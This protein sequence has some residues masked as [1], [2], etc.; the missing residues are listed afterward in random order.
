MLQPCGPTKHGQAIAELAILSS[1]VLII[2]ASI[3]S[4]GQRFDRV[5]EVKMRAFRKA[6]VASYVRNA[7]VNYT[8]KQDFRGMDF[9]NFGKGQPL[10]SMGSSTV[11]WQ[12]GITGTPEEEKD[13]ARG[14]YSFYEVN[15]KLLGTYQGWDAHHYVNDSAGSNAATFPYV[16]PSLLRV[17]RAVYD[18]TQTRQSGSDIYTSAGIYKNVD[19]HISKYAVTSTRDEQGTT[20]T[21]ADNA[22]NDEKGVEDIYWRSDSNAIYYHDPGAP[23]VNQYSTYDAS[24]SG[25]NH[26]E[27]VP[28]FVTSN[29]TRMDGTSANEVRLEACDPTVSD[30]SKPLSANRSWTTAQ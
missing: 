12:K 29:V 4:Y 11:L 13:D 28:T 16:K 21:N 6:L 2:F 20:L 1:L 27:V 14:S 26:I 10:T 18:E 30:C 9:F 17:K 8:L 24:N 22:V 5:G 25:S 7:A 19:K 15:G 23:N 3:I